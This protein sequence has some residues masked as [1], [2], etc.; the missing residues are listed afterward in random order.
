MKNFKDLKEVV[1]NRRTDEYKQLSSHV[2]R[3]EHF[4]VGVNQKIYD[5]NT[6]Y[7]L[8]HGLSI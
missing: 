1:K 7:E 8:S 4:A 5:L 6:A 2:A 3:V